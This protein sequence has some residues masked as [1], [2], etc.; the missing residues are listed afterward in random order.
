MGT[1]IFIGPL[2][3]TKDGPGFAMF[4]TDSMVTL[5]FENKRQAKQ[6]RSVMLQS[7]NALSVPSVKLMT[8]IEQAVKHKGRKKPDI[9]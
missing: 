1:P 3:K 7:S 2:Y 8:A 6:H 5:S 9:V 4:Q